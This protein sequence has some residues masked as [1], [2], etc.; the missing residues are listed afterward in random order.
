MPGKAVKQDHKARPQG[1]TVRQEH[2]I[3]L[4]W[5]N[6]LNQYAT[7]FGVQPLWNA[8]LAQSAAGEGIT[9]RK[10]VRIGHFDYSASF[11]GRSMQNR[12]FKSQKS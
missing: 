3:R 5:L 8:R 7:A 9:L 11:V 4:A 10:I 1:K 2:Q 6:V 12:K